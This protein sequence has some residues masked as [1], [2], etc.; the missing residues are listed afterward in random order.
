[1]KMARLDP[2]YRS[3]FEET[4]RL[5]ALLASSSTMA[6]LHRKVIAEIVHLRLA[7]LLENQMK[8]IFSKLVC[9]AP[10]LDGT[11]PRLLVPP[12]KSA[13]AAVHAMQTLNRPKQIQL[14]WNDGPRIRDG[15]KYLMD[16]NDHSISVVKNF[17]SH[18]TDMRYIRNHIAHKNEGTRVNFR[19]LVR[20]YYGAYVP[21]ITSGTI[22]LSERVSKPC[23]LEVHVRVCRTMIK[24]ITKA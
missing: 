23:L 24:D 4:N 6:A 16:P 2:E 17:A 5:L 7:I 12:S 15:V 19:K 8:T 13:S 14:S 18:L 3:F 11:L 1:M 22:L 9:G 21:G 10:Y 20:R